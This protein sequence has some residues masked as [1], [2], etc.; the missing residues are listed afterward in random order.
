MKNGREI[1]DTK[2]SPFPA[3]W[4][5]DASNGQHLETW[6]PDHSAPPLHAGSVVLIDIGNLIAKFDLHVRLR[7]GLGF[8]LRGCRLV[9]WGAGERV[10]PPQ[11]SHR[12]SIITPPED[13]G[14]QPTIKHRTFYEELLFFDTNRGPRD[15]EQA[16]I[17]AARVAVA[18]A[19]REQQPNGNG[20]DHDHDG[21]PF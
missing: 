6:G 3:N 2:I 17:A 12:I 5:G 4:R 16:A 7:P 1:P 14:G 15:F 11:A 21:V 18:R 8:Y 20:A 19:R 10:F 9:K 13:Q